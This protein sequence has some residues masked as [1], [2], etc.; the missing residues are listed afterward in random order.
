MKNARPEKDDL[1]RGPTALTR[2][3]A[4]LFDWDSTLVDNWR[5]IETAL[6]A[7]LVAMGH[8]PWTAEETRA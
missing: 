1:S 6:N 4:L 8:A 3:R 2:P 7:T 5:S